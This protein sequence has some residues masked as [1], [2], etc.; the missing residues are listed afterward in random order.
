MEGIVRRW[1]VALRDG[2]DR[3]GHLPPAVRAAGTVLRA[4]ATAAAIE[5]LERRLG[6]ALPPSYRSFLAVTDGCSAKPGWGI[7]DPGGTPLDHVGMLPSA[8]V[9]WTR[10]LTPDLAPAYDG[11]SDPADDPD[12]EPDQPDEIYY[13]YSLDHDCVAFRTGHLAGTLQVACFDWGETVLLNPAHVEPDGEWEAW[14]FGNSYPGAFRYRS[15]ATLLAEDLARREARLSEPTSPARSAEWQRLQAE[16]FRVA[17]LSGTDYWASV[18]VDPAAPDEMR[19]W[20][21][22]ELAELPPGPATARALVAAYDV[23]SELGLQI[24]DSW[25]VRGLARNPDP[26]AREGLARIL[27]SADDSS[28]AEQVEQVG[29]LV[30]AWRAGSVHVLPKLIQLGAAHDGAQAP[31]IRAASVSALRDPSLQGRTLH[32][33]LWVA[34]R[35]D[36][37]DPA[38]RAEL[39]AAVAARGD[40]P[41]WDTRWP[42]V[43]ALTRLGAAPEVLHLVAGAERD[44]QGVLTE[45]LAKL[46]KAGHEEALEP[47]LDRVQAKPN[48]DRVTALRYCPH[49]RV[50]GFLEQLASRRGHSGS[51][52]VLAL[53]M[54]WD[55]RAL[56]AL[57]RIAADA[58][59]HA[60]AA[61]ESAAWVRE[62]S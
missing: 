46:V 52:A 61:R 19:D 62:N 60:D 21:I 55:A 6:A 50:V 56:A 54:M 23:G 2:G 12:A 26:V 14:T 5:A 42:A 7:V 15:F 4:P 41:D 3:Q 20:A 17:E 16:R 39:V 8:A 22:R 13:D 59:P 34:G 47:L 11:D 49:D 24:H 10:D 37:A 33:L 53:R 30:D 28:R 40:V 36:V 29:P 57:D 45:A 27:V 18:A 9:G 35:L 38:A 32:D 25:L 51:H 58:G 44:V 1:D 43:R 31:S 48:E